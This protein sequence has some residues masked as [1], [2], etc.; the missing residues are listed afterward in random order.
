MM[1]NQ[2]PDF[3]AASRLLAAGAGRLGLSLTP[4]V[5]SR[6]LIYCQELLRWNDKVNLTGLKTA[7]DIVVKHFLDSLAVWPWV[8][9]L[10]TL[11]DLGAGAGFPGLPLKLVLPHLQLTLV[12]ANGKKT[13][14]LQ[15]ILA[16]LEVA[17]VVVRR[18]HLTP[19]EARAWGPNFQ[20][21]ISRAAW[22]LDRYLE[23]ALP[24]L[25][26][27]GRVLAMQGPQL[28]E[29]HWQRAAAL[30]QEFGC[31]PAV[32]EEYQLPDGSRRRLIIWRQE[33]KNP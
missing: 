31:G 20:G 25:L 8:Q 29:A 1:P 28:D 15:Y 18:L 12:E 7:E 11:A 4:R 32:Q 10:D 13:A 23:L 3:A 24:L 14:F 16:R 33:L 22:P 26:P 19:A 5:Q 21:V 6:F 9:D 30:A 2:Q 27:G 17:G